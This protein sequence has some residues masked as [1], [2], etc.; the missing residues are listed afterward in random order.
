MEISNSHSDDE[1]KLKEKMS[2]IY[3]PGDAG[4]NKVTSDMEKAG[5]GDTSKFQKENEMLGG[6][7]T[8][9]APTEVLSAQAQIRNG[10]IRKVYGILSAQML[11]TVMT[12]CLFMFEPSTHAFVTSSPGLLQLA[13]WAPLGALVALICNRHKYPLNFVLLSVFTFF[14]AYSIGTICAF[15]QAAG[16]GAL[17][18][19]AFILT[20]GVFTSLTT[21]AFFTKTDFSFLQGY[22]YSSLW[23]LIL[24][25]LLTM[26]FPGFFGGFGRT[27][28]SL[29]GCL[30][31]SGY[32]LF[33]TQ[34]IIKRLGTDDYIMAAIELYLDIIN[35]FLYILQL[36]GSSND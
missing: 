16:H 34:M 35:L 13:V 11:L 2:A 27:W 28:M 1:G 12:A 21:Y 9:D 14:E 33:D 23:V 22:L 3:T 20:A 18:L 5:K 36:L 30:V 19:Q 31:F 15:Y 29:F 24:W 8:V 4:S 26:F 6:F 32:I 25:S 7:S 17:V 10:F